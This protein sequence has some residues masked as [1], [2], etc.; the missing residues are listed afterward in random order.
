M[1][2][3]KNTP[4]NLISRFEVNTEL[5]SSSP[6]WKNLIY[7]QLD[8]CDATTDWSA[9]TD[10]VITLNTTNASVKEGTGCLN[11]TK[12]GAT[13]ASVLFSKTIPTAR[14]FTGTQFRLYFYCEDLTELAATGT[15]V[16]IR[17][18]SDSS[19]YYYRNFTRTDIS[20]AAW[21]SLTLDHN[22]SD[23]TNSGT[24][25]TP[26]P[27]ACDFIAINVTYASSSTTVSTGDMRMDDFRF[28][29][30]IDLNVDLT[31]GRIQITDASDYFPS[32]GKDQV[33][34]S[35]LQGGSVPE[36]IKRLA[37]LMTAKGFAKSKLQF[38]NITANEVEG[39]SSAIQNLGV[40]K[41]EIKMILENRRYPP[42]GNMWNQ[43]EGLYVR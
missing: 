40:D 20:S 42:I 19:N 26:T 3:L 27:T 8:S 36:D 24:T 35:Y 22:T 38:L 9:G 2:W 12:T 29:D 39:L 4:V 17:I 30:E 34:T 16:Q 33:R 28:N 11:I 43:N 14:D 18:G 1:F 15:A 5:P 25:G 37:I 10:G 41:E 7:T 23:T 32:T 31:T 6:I 13:Q 21:S